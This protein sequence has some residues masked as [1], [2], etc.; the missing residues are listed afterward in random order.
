MKKTRQ[1]PFE[2]YGASAALSHHQKCTS[3][4]TFDGE[5]QLTLKHRFCL[6]QRHP[7]RY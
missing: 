4:Y 7:C 2:I 3:M 6:N 5:F 1:H